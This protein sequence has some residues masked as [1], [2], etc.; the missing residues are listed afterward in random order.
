MI[1]SWTLWR[2]A[3]F[4]SRGSVRRGE[5]L[6]A[7]SHASASHDTKPVRSRLPHRARFRRRPAGVDLTQVF[8][9]VL[10][11]LQFKRV[12]YPAHIL[13]FSALGGAARH[14]LSLVV[15][16]LTWEELRV[17]SLRAQADSHMLLRV[18]RAIEVPNGKPTPISR[19]SCSPMSSRTSSRTIP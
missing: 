16:W 17:T 12:T 5:G 8:G 1:S 11:V 6:L 2:V 9:F 10:L 3:L 19:K 14:G 18:G 13:P 4:M 7:G 15:E